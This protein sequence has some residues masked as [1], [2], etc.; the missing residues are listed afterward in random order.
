MQYII[1]PHK[2]FSIIVHFLQARLCV[3]LPCSLIGCAEKESNNNKK[4]ISKNFT[5]LLRVQVDKL[6]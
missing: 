5:S 4:K 2:I 3:M 1:N 6:N